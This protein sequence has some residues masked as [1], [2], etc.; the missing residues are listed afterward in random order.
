MSYRPAGASS[1]IARTNSSIASV[2]RLAGR[3]KLFDMIEK[4]TDWPESVVA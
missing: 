4:T 2:T 1:T 3:M